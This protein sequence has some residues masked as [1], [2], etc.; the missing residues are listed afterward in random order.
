MAPNESLAHLMT[1]NVVR[2][3]NFEE[4]M[5]PSQWLKT[6]EANMDLLKIPDENKLKIV[7]GYLNPVIVSEWLYSYDFEEWKE[8]KEKFVER[9]QIVKVNLNVVMAQLMSI[10][11]HNG[12]SIHHFVERFNVL[13]TKYERNRRKTKEWQEINPTVLKDT[14][15]NGLTPRSLKLMVKQ[16]IPKNL[17]EAQAVAIEEDEQD[18]EQEYQEKI[19]ISRIEKGDNNVTKKKE[20]HIVTRD[21]DGQRVTSHK[22]V[23]NSIASNHKHS[24]MEKKMDALTENFLKLSLLVERNQ[25]NSNKSATSQNRCYNCQENGHIA[26]SCNGP[27]KVCKGQMGNHPF[28]ECPNYQN[29][30]TRE[31]YLVLKSNKSP[32]ETYAVEKKA[33]KYGF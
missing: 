12:E 19:S 7:S 2:V 29:R 15:V 20:E 27:C 1:S 25:N 10:K 30:N 4:S 26:S 32:L 13:H 5:E 9:F 11:R 33:I 24:E 18:E 21:Q 14:F 3:P 22:E 17:K 8:F 16:N 28:W 23:N 6:F 31:S